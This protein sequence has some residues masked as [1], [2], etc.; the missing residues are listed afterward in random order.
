M[1]GIDLESCKLEDPS[2]VMEVMDAREMLE[3]ADEHELRDV[4]ERY[5]RM[6]D[7]TVRAAEELLRDHGDHALTPITHLIVRAQYYD[8]LVQEAE[9]RL[10]A[11]QPHKCSHC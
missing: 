3:T 5:R 6:L 11:R 2:L 8:K 9:A 4:L 1:K 7:E 10:E